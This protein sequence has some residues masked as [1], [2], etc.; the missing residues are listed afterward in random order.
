M[1]KMKVDSIKEKIRL[2]RDENKHLFIMWFTTL[3][4]IVAA[5]Y[6]IIGGT[7]RTYIK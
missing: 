3:C 4:A 6:K 1:D 5:S 7:D 2:L